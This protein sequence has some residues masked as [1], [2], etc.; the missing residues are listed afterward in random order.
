MKKRANGTN[1]HKKMGTRAMRKRLLLVFGL[2]FFACIGLSA[3]I[4]QLHKT[5]GDSYQK[6]ALAQQ[7]Y[8]SKAIN[9]KRGDIVDRNGNKLATSKKIY[10]LIL[11]VATMTDQDGKYVDDTKE[12]LHSVFGIDKD[13]IDDIVRDNP[14][15]KYYV[16]KEY[17]ELS[18]S[19]VDEW[20]AY[21]EE[22]IQK[23]KDTGG[24]GDSMIRGVWFEDKYK[25]V[26]P[27]ATVGSNIIGFCA[28]VNTGSWGIE[29]SYNSVL[30]GTYGRQYGY[31]DSDLNLIE[32]IKDA[33]NGNTVM[34][35][36][37]VNV[38]GVL[39]QHI[40]K[41]MKKVGAKN[42]GVILMN[43]NNGE[44]Y[45]MATNSLYDLNNP[46]DLSAQ[47]TKKQI[48]KMNDQEQLDA[49]NQMWRNFCI[50]D[51]YEPGSTF[52]PIT[53]AACLDEGI[54]NI[55][56]R[57]TCDGGQSV[58][59]R[60][61]KCVAHSYG[62]HGNINVGQALMVSC[63]DVM[64][65]LAAKL[66]KEKFIDY[67]SEF[68]YGRNTGID[69]PGE[70]TGTVF[71]KDN[72]HETE[73]ATSSF[74]QGQTVTMIQMAA[75]ISA[76]IN[77]GKYYQPHVMKRVNTEDG[78]LVTS[79][80]DTLQSR[81]ITEKTSKKIRKYLYKTVEEGTASPAKVEGYKIG[82]KT[83][84]AEKVPRGHGNYLVSF[85]GCVPADDP[86]LLSYVVIDEP[87]VEDQAHSTYAT[88]F[89]SK[90]LKDVLPLLKIYPE[91][92]KKNKN[93]KVTLPSNLSWINGDEAMQGS[94]S[95]SDELAGTDADGN[96]SQDTV[97]DASQ[98]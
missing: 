6:K 11:D 27:Y 75:A 13:E 28:D 55:T 67:V 72:M 39:E 91:G 71:T 51:S 35:T 22:K 73:L 87:N 36:I 47:Y 41:F 94:Y 61:I 88:E 65:Q 85:I 96:T 93:P 53:V 95:D 63:N 16:M 45:A 81:V 1:H 92:T 69:L 34:S 64:M 89:T 8:V 90:L 79:N 56:S 12:A 46:R 19:Q 38:Q 4:Q 23:D 17:K 10:G 57:F 24:K 32:N 66:G 33:T 70:A 3:R 43:P 49:L 29:N 86:Q 80:E 37:D 59:D 76:V 2:V 77:G 60:Y 42:V 44:I 18:Q 50:S 15:S 78:A 14:K 48:A 31:Y 54:A 7:S 25:R 5:K 20:E 58:A 40:Q 62:G 97:Q 9:Y 30:N 68:G 21:K 74:G 98:E 82:G 84:T 52:K 26:Y 83:G